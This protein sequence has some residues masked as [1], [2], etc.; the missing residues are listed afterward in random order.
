MDILIFYLRI[1]T[2][3]WDFSKTEPSVHT[4]FKCQMANPKVYSHTQWRKR[5]QRIRK[6]C[7]HP[8]VLIYIISVNGRKTLI[9]LPFDPLSH[10]Y[11][12]MWASA[13]FNLHAQCLHKMPI[14]SMCLHLSFMLESLWL[15][16]IN[17]TG[18]FMLHRDTKDILLFLES[19][20]DRIYVTFV[21]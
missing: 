1:R 7:V 12:L 20:L 19:N 11:L 13:C 10:E 16:Q 21:V 17:S 3:Y 9:S 14:Y 6:V 5:W 18:C 4:P 15:I 2:L 8:P